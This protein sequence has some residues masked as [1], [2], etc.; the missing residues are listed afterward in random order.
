[1][2]GLSSPESR[3]SVSPGFSTSAPLDWTGG[4]GVTVGVWVGEAV[5]VGISVGV[6]VWVGVA[7]GGC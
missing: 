4:V 2:A 1:M 3:F 5:E 7:V 6:E